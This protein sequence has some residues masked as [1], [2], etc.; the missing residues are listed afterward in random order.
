MALQ[1]KIYEKE[2][3]PEK[4]KPFLISAVEKI[5]DDELKK[6]LIEILEKK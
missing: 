1:G 4:I 6:I 2:T 3:D 5:A